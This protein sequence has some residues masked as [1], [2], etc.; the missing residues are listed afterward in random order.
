MNLFGINSADK[1]QMPS[2]EDALPGRE[3]EM[4]IAGQHAV[5]NTPLKPPFPP[6]TE[7]AMFGM[8]CFWGAEKL[9]WQLKGVYSTAVG[10]GAGFTPNP[11]YEEVCCGKTG[12]NEVV[13]VV[14]DPAVITYAD[15][16]KTFWENHN[17]T[18]GMRQG[19]D[20]GTQYRSGIYVFN[21]Q[22]KDL[23]SESQNNYQQALKENGC[24]DQT[25]EII[26]DAPFYY[27]EDYHQQYLAKNPGGYCPNHT[28][29]ANPPANRSADSQRRPV[30]RL[31]RVRGALAPFYDRFRRMGPRHG[32]YYD[33]R[34]V[35]ARSTG[36]GQAR[37][38]QAFPDLPAC[39]RAGVY[40]VRRYHQHS[41]RR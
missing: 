36:A 39:G 13:L 34:E 2:P 4:V 38:E 1:I 41:L 3:S 37:R 16:L 10:Y 18:E 6:S 12:H 30:G 21:Q 32:H 11:N 35:R 28:C 33:V 29:S 23:A 24:A 40:L 26:E 15:L 5:L 9:F 22:Q 14:F 19:N 20:V 25:T 31:I 7:I 27:A 8:G 17:P